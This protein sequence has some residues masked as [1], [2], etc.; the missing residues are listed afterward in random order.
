MTTVTQLVT[1]SRLLAKQMEPCPRHC[2]RT[3]LPQS[4]HWA[5]PGRHSTGDR[6][7]PPHPALSQDNTAFQG[8]SSFGSLRTTILHARQH[9]NIHRLKRWQNESLLITQRIVGIQSVQYFC[10]KLRMFAQCFD[11]F[12]KTPFLVCFRHFLFRSFTEYIKLYL[13]PY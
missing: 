10:Q 2:S 5:H 1:S 8:P 6:V 9:T 7:T 12:L 13:W 11:I 4:M 3:R